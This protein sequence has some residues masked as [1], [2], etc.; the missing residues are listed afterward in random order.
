MAAFELNDELNGDRAFRLI[1]NTFVT[2]FWRSDLLAETLDWL[3]EHGYQVVDVDAGDCVDTVSLLD[4]LASALNFPDY[5]GRNLDALN[6]CM[7]DVVTGDY[8]S[9]LDATGFVL[10]LRRYD[11]FAGR[12]ATAAHAV[13]DILADQCRNGAIIGHRMMC[14]VQSDDPR[15]HLPPVGA[16][17]VMWNDAEW[18][19]SRRGARGAS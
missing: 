12:E 7:R 19:A 18:L 3:A 2:M 13:L 8:G 16:T 6:D 10:V 15:L 9:D 5:F 11:S 1:H 4:R 14:L 17:P